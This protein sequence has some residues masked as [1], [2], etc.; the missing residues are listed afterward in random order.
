MGF[1][2]NIIYIEIDIITVMVLITKM[3]DEKIP[4]NV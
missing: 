2:E 3:R 1:N 4:L